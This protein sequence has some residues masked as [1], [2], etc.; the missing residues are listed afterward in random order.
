[1]EIDVKF[2]QPLPGIGIGT[3]HMR[4]AL[5][6]IGVLFVAACATVQPPS[7]PP[8]ATSPTPA[9]VIVV[10]PIK[11]P[12]APAPVAPPP[13]EPPKIN[14][15]AEEA[16][17]LVSDLQKLVL[18]SNDEQKREL[19]AATQAVLRQRSDV[20]RLRLG[21]LQSLPAGGAD[22]A[23]ALAT[24]E[25][26][27]KQGNGPTKMVAI[28]L[29]AQIGERQRALREER[30]RAEDLQQKLDALKALER[31]LLGRERRPAP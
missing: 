10:Q 24:L 20:A 15:E 8:A 16:L 7:A 13:P 5:A 1:M 21:M 12:E 28:V 9:A 18:A 25:P 27:L 19:T 31:S 4:A 6:G 2:E 3:M 23:R 14:E 11:Q 17:A 22:E 29:I 30:K 26:L